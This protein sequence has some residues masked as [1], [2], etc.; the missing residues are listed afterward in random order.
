MILKIHDWSFFAIRLAQLD[1]RRSAERE[2]LKNIH[3]AKKLGFKPT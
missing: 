3:A 2:S 1:K